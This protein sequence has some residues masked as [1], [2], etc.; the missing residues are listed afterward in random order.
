MDGIGWDGWDGVNGYHRSSIGLLR[1][2]LVPKKNSQTSK[3][4]V[5][6]GSTEDGLMKGKRQE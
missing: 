5:D 3:S 2:P 4:K 6:Q 1:E